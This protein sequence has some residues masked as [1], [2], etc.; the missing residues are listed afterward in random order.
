MVSRASMRVEAERR[1]ISP[2]LLCSVLSKRIRLLATQDP[3]SRIAELLGLACH[4]FM[5]GKLSFNPLTEPT[6]PIEDADRA[7]PD[8]AA[9]GTNSSSTTAESD[10]HATLHVAV[11]TIAA[12]ASP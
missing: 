10:S 4:E 5:V 8:A 1:S 12:H 6:A 9:H 3:N 2:F 7:M 11:Q